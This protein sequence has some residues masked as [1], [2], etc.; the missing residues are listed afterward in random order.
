MEKF[1]GNLNMEEYLQQANDN[2]LTIVQIETQEALTSIDDIAS[3]SGV[4]VLFI[5][6]FDLGNNIGSP[7]QNGRMAPELKDAIAKILQS[8]RAHHK[9]TAI[10]AVNGEQAREFVEQGF[11]MISVVND[12]GALQMYLSSALT[13]AAGK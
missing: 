8:G 7:I 10:Y 13:T 3:I 11:D 5:G 9:P 2:L 1:G 12:V 6:P 4:D